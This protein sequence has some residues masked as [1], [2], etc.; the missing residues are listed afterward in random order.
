MDVLKTQLQTSVGPGVNVMMNIL[1]KGFS[2]E[3]K[4]ILKNQCY[5]AIFAL[6]T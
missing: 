3:F 2:A 6:C 5:A 1:N 4:K